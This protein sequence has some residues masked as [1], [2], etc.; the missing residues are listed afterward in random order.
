MKDN[1]KKEDIYNNEQ[2]KNNKAIENARKVIE[3][4]D[5]KSETKKEE[6]KNNIER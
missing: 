3:I 4:V 6:K 1:L 5:M 2:E